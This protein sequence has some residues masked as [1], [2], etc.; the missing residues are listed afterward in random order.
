MTDIRSFF[1]R[2]HEGDEGDDENSSASLNSC[3]FDTL[4]KVKS[5]L[6]AKKTKDYKP[7]PKR[8]KKCPPETE[9]PRIGSDSDVSPDYEVTFKR[10]LDFELRPSLIPKGPGEFSDESDIEVEDSPKEMTFEEPIE[11]NSEAKDEPEDAPKKEEES[12]EEYEVEI[13]LDYKWCLATVLYLTQLACAK[14][15]IKTRAYLADSGYVFCQM[16]WL[17]RVP[18]HLG[19]FG[20]LD[21][22]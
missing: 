19:A 5:S 16:A 1:K 7:K 3:D 20:Q 17:G 9:P 4:I 6:E 8:F 22:M 2:K 13:I 10:P 15:G 14:K 21:G 18:K 12:E 11:D